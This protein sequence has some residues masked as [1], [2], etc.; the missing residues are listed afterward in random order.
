MNSCCFCESDV[1]EKE[2][3]KYRFAVAGH[4]YGNSETYTS[5]VYPPF[6]EQLKKDHQEFPITYLFLTGDVVAH[7]TDSNWNNVKSELDE[8]GIPWYI[9][10][11]NHDISRYMDEKIQPFKYKAIPR[12]NFLF[13]VLNTS[14]PGWTPDS[15]QQTFIQTSLE[16]NDSLE[17]IFVFSH[18]LWWI[19]NPPDS[20]SIDS[21]RT[22]SH[23]L[24][25]GTK[26]FWQNTFPL[27]VEE[28]VET[29]F[30]GGD[31]G[32]HRLIPSYYEDHYKQFHF[33]GSGMGGGIRD[34]YL[35]VEVFG[36]GNIQVKRVDF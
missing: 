6:L 20:L 8:V 14:H 1:I 3:P 7:P 9:A 24:Y 35:L 27:F 17:A 13:L 32:S 23:A 33:Y 15:M 29:W 31:L 30:F 28:D 5:S 25:E 22:N 10:P 11:G 19:K 21:I 36:K 2:N 26:D 12:D 34:N 18:Q 4:V 16:S